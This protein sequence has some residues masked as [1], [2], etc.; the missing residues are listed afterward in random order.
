[1]ILNMRESCTF[2]AYASFMKYNNVMM[3][4]EMLNS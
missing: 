2:V 1:M 4:V 3:S